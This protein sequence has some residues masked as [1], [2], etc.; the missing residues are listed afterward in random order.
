VNLKNARNASAGLVNAKEVNTDL[1]KLMDF[2]AYNIT[3]WSYDK[4]PI[5][6]QLKYLE[7]KLNYLGCLI[8][9]L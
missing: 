7:V 8:V 1:I 4:I 6:I 2:I 9:Q 5:G 3:D